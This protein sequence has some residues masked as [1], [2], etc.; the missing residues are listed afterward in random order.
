MRH[1]AL[2]PLLAL[3]IP[4]AGGCGGSQTVAG[5]A[6][7]GHHD[8]GSDRGA[9][10][11]RTHGELDDKDE[12]VQ[13]GTLADHYVLPVFAGERLTIDMRSATL[14]TYLILN[15][16]TGSQLTSDDDSGGN[17][18]SHIEYRVSQTDHVTIVATSYGHERGR[19]DLSVLQEGGAT[20]HLVT[21]PAVVEGRLGRDATNALSATRR[22]AYAVDVAASGRLLVD[23]TT[24]DGRALGSDVYV[25]L[26]DEWGE[27]LPGSTRGANSLET[28]AVGAGR[29]YVIVSAKPGAPETDF[30]LRIRN[31]T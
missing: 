28:D 24:G 10:H 19:Y 14:D 2:I 11:Y 25:T 9:R 22:S 29:Y 15:D 17:L 8:V 30:V 31:T 1:A 16:S 21:V 7:L 20:Y 3:A 12:T 6:A 27:E 26:F 4:L 18:N 5:P 23:V 13:R